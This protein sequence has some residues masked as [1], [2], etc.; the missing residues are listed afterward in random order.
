MKKITRVV[1]II[2]ICTAFSYSVRAQN[3]WDY[4]WGYSTTMR[5]YSNKA[6]MKK[7]VGKTGK[8]KT[9]PHKPY[10][11]YPHA[12]K[13]TYDNKEE[14]VSDFKVQNIAIEVLKDVD[15]EKEGAKDQWEAY[16]MRDKAT[17]ELMDDF[18]QSIRW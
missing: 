10:V 3:S 18:K 6:A 13:S 17:N 8:E 16:R 9:V 12:G 14:Q 15:W 5:H 7:V 4:S 1:S 2:F 11:M